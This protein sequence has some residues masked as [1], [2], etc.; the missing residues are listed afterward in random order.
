MSSPYLP[1]VV[2]VSTASRLIKAK[3]FGHGVRVGTTP[4][5]NPVWSKFGTVV[6]DMRSESRYQ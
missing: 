3:V 5:G 2:E 4:A 6:V 1:D